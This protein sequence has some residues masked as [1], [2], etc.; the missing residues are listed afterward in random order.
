MSSRRKKYVDHTV[1]CSGC[2]DVLI[3]VFAQIVP[4]KVVIGCR[5][6]QLEHKMLDGTEPYKRPRRRASD[7]E[8]TTHVEIVDQTHG[9]FYTP[10][11]VASACRCTGGRT[12]D[13][14]ELVA[15]PGGFSTDSPK[16]AGN[17]GR[18]T[19]R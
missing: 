15:R 8:H 16:H 11:Q 5:T 19:W 6:R 2:G 3:E 9:S 17:D 10:G 13:V 7:W 12:F 14:N 18:G 4:G 1:R